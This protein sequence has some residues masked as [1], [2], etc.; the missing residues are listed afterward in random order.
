MNNKLPKRDGTNRESRDL[1]KLITS[2]RINERIV[3]AD[4]RYQASR[5]NAFPRN[6]DR[7]FPS[8]AFH[9]LVKRPPKTA[10]ENR[11]W[12]NLNFVK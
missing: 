11:E 3:L 5:L 2:S 4:V 12:T 7:M 10:G 9:K 8:V 6:A 1:T